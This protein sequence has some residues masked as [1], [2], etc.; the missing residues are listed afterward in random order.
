MIP[1]ISLTRSANAAAAPT[2]RALI[3]DARSAWNNDPCSTIGI[4]RGSGTGPTAGRVRTGAHAGRCR[5]GWR[6]VPGQG[7]VRGG[8]GPSGHG[9][10]AW[11]TGSSA[12]GGRAASCE[13]T[14]TARFGLP[15]M[16]CELVRLLPRH[17]DNDETQR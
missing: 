16:M 14:N 1:G 10:L 13:E 6:V 12:V 15:P 5:P 9:T 3:N 2:G 11:L 17:I 4:A 8:G 7:A